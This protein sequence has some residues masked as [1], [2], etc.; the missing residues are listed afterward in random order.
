MKLI[1]KRPCSFGGKK[2]YIGDVIPAA[3]VLD[4]KAHE[5]YGTITI[6]EEEAAAPVASLPVVVHANE[7][8]L[9][10]T[11]TAESLQAVVDVMTATADD[12]AAL[13]KQMEDRDALALLYFADSRKT[14]KQAAEARARAV[15]EANAESEEESAGEQ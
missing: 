11:L 9:P 1:A 15:D 10:L 3:L 8:D 5:Q 14:V 12:A 13:I 4:P 2:F 6:V 7:G